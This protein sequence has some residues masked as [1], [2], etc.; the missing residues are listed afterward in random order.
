MD[1]KDHLRYWNK[2]ATPPVTALKDIKGGRLSGMTDIN[3]QWRY[4]VMTEEFGPIGFGWKYEEVERWTEKGAKDE[5][6]AFEKVNVYY[7][8]DNE[9]SAPI[10]GIGGSSLV[11][12]EKGGMHNSDEAFKM[13]LT[14]ALSVALAKIGVGA[15]VYMGLLAGSKYAGEK[16]P[17]KAMQRPEQQKAAE[18]PI[19]LAI[20]AVKLKIAAA[21]KEKG[22]SNEDAQALLGDNLKNLNAAKT[23]PQVDDAR[24]KCLDIIKKAEP[25][26]SADSVKAKLAA[27]KT[28][29]TPA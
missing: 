23:V 5:I 8:V 19:Q 22:Y 15:D 2:L 20:K 18:D 16:Q 29:A 17:S 21:L 13:A 7:K 28:E 12:N 3:P 24:V 27:T 25:K 11:A 14:D 6:M 1:M 26:G 4:K 9:W 10:P